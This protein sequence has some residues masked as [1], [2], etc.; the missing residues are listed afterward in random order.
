[1]M[2][3][4]CWTRTDS[5]K[6]Q[7]SLADQTGFSR[8]D[9]LERNQLG[10]NNSNTNSAY[11]MQAT[12]ETSFVVDGNHG[13][14]IGDTTEDPTSTI[15]LGPTLTTGTTLSLDANPAALAVNA[16]RFHR[17]HLDNLVLCMDTSL[18]DSK[19]AFIDDFD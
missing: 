4:C 9:G 18:A 17:D 5:A 14:T 11:L 3:G 19:I 15:T 1:M 2:P 16:Y 7:G 12:T 6:S 13:D 8:N 10:L